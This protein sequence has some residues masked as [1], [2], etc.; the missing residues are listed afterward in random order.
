MALCARHDNAN[1]RDLVSS[2]WQQFLRK[3]LAEQIGQAQSR[4]GNALQQATVRF[5]AGGMLSF[6]CTTC[7]PTPQGTLR[8]VSAQGESTFIPLQHIREFTVKAHGQ[9]SIPD[10]PSPLDAT[11]PPSVTSELQDSEANKSALLQALGESGNAAAQPAQASRPQL[12]ASSHEPER[13]KKPFL[14]PK[15]LPLSPRRSLAPSQAPNSLPEASPQQPEASISSPIQPESMP[16][17]P[18]LSASSLPQP[19]P[20]LSQPEPMPDLP[21]PLGTVFSDSEE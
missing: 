20:S 2:S 12:P 7:E 21:A 10:A 14:A 4:G 11:K 16:Q 15:P 8:I 1:N 6:L 13:V 3:G 9:P 5:L 19:K 17:Q 18:E